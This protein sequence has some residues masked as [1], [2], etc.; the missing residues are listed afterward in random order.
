MDAGKKIN[1]RK[2]HVLT[3]TLGPILLALVTAGDV[4]DQ[5]GVK[6]LLEPVLSVL[7]RL[8]VIWADA[9]YGVHLLWLALSLKI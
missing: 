3:D 4:H 8:Q 2:R 7:R 5:D 9:K 6:L 1:G